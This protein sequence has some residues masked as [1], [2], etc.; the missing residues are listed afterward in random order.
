VEYPIVIQ[1]RY[2]KVSSVI[3]TENWPTQQHIDPHNNTSWNKTIITVAISKYNF[4]AGFLNVHNFIALYH[5]TISYGPHFFSQ[6]KQ[7][8]LLIF[9]FGILFLESSFLSIY[10]QFPFLHF[11]LPNPMLF[12]RS[13][14]VPDAEV[15]L[16]IENTSY[17][18]VKN[19]KKK[20]IYS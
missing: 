16:K 10:L 5:I 20:K 18:W 13:L 6:E 3:N 15:L 9:S 12:Y 14:P 7:H 11:Q 17:F 2:T 19:S 1:H 4:Q 8:F